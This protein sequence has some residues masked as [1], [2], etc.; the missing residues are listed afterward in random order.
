MVK[1]KAACRVSY[2]RLSPYVKGIIFGMFLAGSGL[3]EIADKVVKSDGTHPCQ[4]AVAMTVARC[5]Q[6][7]GTK[8]DGEVQSEGRGPPR[9]TTNALDRKIKKIVFKHRGK[10]KVTVDFIRKKIPSTRRLSRRTISRRLQEQGLAWLRRRRK[11]LVPSVHKKARIDFSNWVLKRTMATL[12]RWVYTDGTS[13]YLA[14]TASEKESKMR[15]ALGTHVWRMA[16]GS[17]ALY[18]DV[19]GPSAYWK[20]QGTCIRV[21]GLLVAGMLFVTVVPKGEAV[22]RWTYARII[23]QCFPRWVRKVMGRKAKAIL[24]QDHERA[25]WTD[26]ARDAIRKAGLTL[27]ESY[28]KCSQGLNVIETA[29][30]ELRERL[31]ATE[32]VVMEDRKAFVKR[33]HLAVSW[34]NRNRLTYLRHECRAQK[35]RAKDVLLQKGGRTKH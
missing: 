22:N 14:R 34:V 10:A 5:K 18:E 20:A 23:A 12:K 2:A 13:F 32:P 24:V 11:S 30:R 1:G 25:L 16:S 29:W 9:V 33:L 15:G 28:P 6:E 17:D 31:C 21:W 7:G 26:E 4:Q 35:E 8:W 27:L 3:Q 19:I